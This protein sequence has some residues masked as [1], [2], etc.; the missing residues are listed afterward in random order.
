MSKREIAKMLL[1]GGILVTAGS[2]AV[3]IYNAQQAKTPITD[4][5]HILA[6]AALVIGLFLLWN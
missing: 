1:L 4:Y 5:T 6:S 2:T 3:S